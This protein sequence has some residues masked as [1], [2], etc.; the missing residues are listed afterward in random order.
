MS[1]EAIRKSKK[2]YNRELGKEVRQLLPYLS[3][4]VAIGGDCSFRKVRS[5]AA[6]VS[7]G[8][9]LFFW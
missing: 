5:A 2:S 4:D 6:V 9:L 3:V 8:L 1:V 7:I